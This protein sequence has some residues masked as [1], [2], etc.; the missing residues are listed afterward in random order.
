MFSGALR[1]DVRNAEVWETGTSELTFG[2]ICLALLFTLGR[3]TNAKQHWG[4]QLT[5]QSASNNEKL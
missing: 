1:I 2:N 3:Q 5:Q 4:D